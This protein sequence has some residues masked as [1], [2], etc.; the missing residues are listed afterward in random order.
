MSGLAAIMQPTFGDVLISKQSSVPL[1]KNLGKIV[2]LDTGSSLLLKGCCSEH[3]AGQN[4]APQEGHPWPKDEA[5]L[6]HVKIP[7]YVICF[8]KGKNQQLVLVKVTAS[9]KPFLSTCS[10]GVNSWSFLTQ[11]IFSHSLI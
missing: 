2:L 1:H 4:P 5:F 9:L 7:K 11:L 8:I 3:L 10:Y 6:F